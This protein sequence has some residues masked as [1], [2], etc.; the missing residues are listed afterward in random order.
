[1]ARIIDSI[2]G[3]RGRT[4]RP[5]DPDYEAARQIFNGM[6]DRHP[7]LIVRVAGGDDVARTIEYAR[8]HDL[9]LSIRGGGHNVAGNALVEGGVVID[10]SDLRTV[11][12]DPASRT[13]DA[14][15]GARW[16]D[17]DQATQAHGL[18]VTGGLVSDTGV[19]GFTLGGGIG[20]LVRRHGLAC[21]NLIEADV[22]TADG[23]RLTASAVEDA[24]LLWALRGGGGNFGVVTRFRFQVHPVERVTGGLLVYPRNQAVELLRL[25]R[26]FVAD[27]PPDLTTLVLLGTASDA[28]KIVAIA[29][30]HAGDPAAAERDL[31]PLRAFSRPLIEQVAV[32]PYAVFQLALDKARQAR[33]AP[34]WNTRAYWKADFMKALTDEA[35]EALVEAGNRMEPGLSQVHLHHLGGAMRSEPPGGSAFPIRGAGF[36]YNLVAEWL[37]PAGDGVHAEWARSAFERLRPYSRGGAYVNFLGDDGEARVR[38]AYGGNYERLAAL[39]RRYDSENVFRLNQNIRPA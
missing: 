34:R 13:A 32:M 22:V 37:D 3:I 10:H 33:G 29:F 16:Y 11:T 28:Q 9:P 1:M 35:I 31:A 21:D 20:W 23:R 17:F 12:V 38:A 15:P 14:S 39:K 25:W 5:G 30:C 8:E 36:V 18:A 26:E 27:A 4:I 2:N 19:A 24:D 7:A 6:I